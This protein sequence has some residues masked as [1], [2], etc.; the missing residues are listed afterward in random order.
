MIEHGF[1]FHQVDA[2]PLQILKFN[3]KEIFYHCD[4]EFNE[5]L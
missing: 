1:T 5:M 4:E 3:Y 2:P